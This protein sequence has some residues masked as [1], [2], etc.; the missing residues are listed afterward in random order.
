MLK[1]L[2]HI[3][4]R[5]LQHIAANFGPHTRLHKEP[6]LI[7]LM[8]HRVL[9]KT[10]NRAKIEEPGMMVTPETFRLHMHLIKQRFDVLTLSQWLDAKHNG[11]KLPAI[12][13]CITFD[14]G[15]ADNY[16]Y[17]YPLLQEFNLPATIFL[18]SEMIGT[19]KLFWP[20]RLAHTLTEIA[21]NCPE[22]WQ[23]PCLDWINRDTVS[24]DFSANPP[25]KEQLSEIIHQAKSLP[26]DTIHSL[27]NT[28]ENTLQLEV[29]PTP[30]LLNW[31]QMN[32]MCESGLIEAGCHTCNHIRLNDSQSKET[33]Q[34]EIIDSKVQIEKQLELPVKTFCY[35]N[36]DHSPEAI[37][38]V[39]QYYQCAVTTK[40]DWNTASTD[41]H[42]LNR[43][44]IHEDISADKTAFLA[45]LSGWM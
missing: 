42:L 19:N 6:Q 31:Q 43:I 14:D 45:R 22:N 33:L 40:K 27:I 25:K 38:L 4:K 9:P 8:Y 20:E 2:K 39:K 29:N 32:E 17:A 10:D 23:H 28:I 13:C 1:P 16:E 30:S 3:T 24:Y 11:D 21:L 36:G 5:S 12:C 37:E 18:V 34:M 26:D 35:P 44:G 7:V 41:E 15:W